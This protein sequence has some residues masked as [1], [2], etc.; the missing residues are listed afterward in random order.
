MIDFNSD[1]DSEISISEEDDNDEKIY[2]GLLTNEIPPIVYGGVATWIVNFIKMFEGHKNIIVVPIY[3]AYNDALPKE[4]YDKYA[5]IRVIEC[6]SD[7]KEAFSGI[8]VCINNLWIAEETIEKVLN[9][10][11]KGDQILFFLN[12][13]GFAP[14]V[15]CKKCYSKFEIIQHV[16]EVVAQLIDFAQLI[17][18]TDLPK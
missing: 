4:C 9:H 18:P 6:E 2:I 14:S 12:R 17:C 5:N 8:D 7:I 16:D 10:L 13:R 15:I 11:N 3:L 1:E